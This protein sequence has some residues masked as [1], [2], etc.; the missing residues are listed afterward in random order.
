MGRETVVA[1]IDREVMEHVRIV[2]DVEDYPS[3][4]LRDRGAVV[5]EGVKRGEDRS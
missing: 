3:V 2:T 1:A 5:Q 4:F